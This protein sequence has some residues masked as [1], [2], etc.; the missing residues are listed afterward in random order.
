VKTSATRCCFSDSGT[1]SKPKCV[2][3]EPGA[4][5]CCCV[6]GG[7]EAGV[8][9]EKGRF[10]RLNWGWREHRVQLWR[11]RR[12]IGGRA[13]MFA[14]VELGCGSDGA[15]EKVSSDGRLRKTALTK[16]WLCWAGVAGVQPCVGD[17]GRWK[18][19]VVWKRSM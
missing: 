3:D 2:V 18:V 12:R 13:A 9:D 5:A 7:D 1:V 4:A 10:V 11:A 14:G 16:V 8:E 15:G 19:G 6:G 17:V